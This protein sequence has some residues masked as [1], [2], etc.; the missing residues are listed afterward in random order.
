MAIPTS[1]VYLQRIRSRAQDAY[2]RISEKPVQIVLRDA[3]GVAIAPQT[4]RLEHDNGATASES[5]P[6]AVTR[7]KCILFGTLGHCSHPDFNVKKGYRFT[8][9]VGGSKREWE[10]VS[11][12][13][14]CGERQATAESHA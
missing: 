12:I 11:V 7:R 5:T 4:V 3:K 10:V 8:L 2:R 13:D 1:P 6:G 9:V 14:S